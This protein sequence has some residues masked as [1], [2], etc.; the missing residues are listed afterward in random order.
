M[1][2]TSI[3]IQTDR[4][5]G[6]L[7]LLLLLIQKEEMSFKDIDINLI[8]KQYLSYLRKMK[9]LNFDSAGDYLYMAA[10]LVLLKS[11]SCIKEEDL[12]DL[13]SETDLCGPSITGRADLIKRLEDLSR[14]QRLGEKLWKLPK[15]GHEIFIKPRVNRRRFI[16]SMVP[17]VSLDELTFSMI[18]YLKRDKRKFTQIAKDPYP[19]KKKLEELKEL[20]FIGKELRFDDCMT[21]EPEVSEFV[22]TFISILEL[23]R[24][25]KIEI[26]QNEK[27]IYVKVL[28]D[29]ANF[30]VEMADGFE[31]KEDENKISDEELIPT[32]SLILP[33]LFKTQEAQM[34]LLQ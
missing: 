13:L 4:F 25:K 14:F 1:L 26:F 22:V 11:R 6:P 2:D 17:D 31:S 32:E 19:I 33:E 8:T 3:Q 15:T 5:D 10:T 23:A 30:D 27:V 34:D 7:G 16:N 24:L 20:F 21:K 29:L 9:D 28:K 12:S 18:D